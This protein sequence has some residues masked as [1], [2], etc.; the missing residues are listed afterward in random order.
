[1]MNTSNQ[2][3]DSTKCSWAQH[4]EV[5]PRL[6]KPLADLLPESRR[7]T[8]ELPGSAELPFKGHKQIFE[9]L[10]NGDKCGKRC[11]SSF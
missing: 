3:C 5:L 10:K 6:L 8:S 1:M 7:V 4:N 2:I 11:V 9:A